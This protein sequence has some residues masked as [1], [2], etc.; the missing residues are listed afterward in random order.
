MLLLKVGECEAMRIL[1]L[2]NLTILLCSTN[3]NTLS[4]IWVLNFDLTDCP[5]D[6]ISFTYQL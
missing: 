6:E 2:C 4:T 5:Q 3:S 1:K